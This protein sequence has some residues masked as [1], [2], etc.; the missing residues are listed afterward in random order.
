MTVFLLK[1][2]FM[3]KLI[4]LM[5]LGILFACWSGPSSSSNVD[6]LDVAIRD[7]SD[8]LNSNI[9][10]GSKI[11]ILNIQ[12]TSPDLSD[13]V[14]DE[15]IA[16]AV[17]DRVFSVVDRQQLDTIR[18]EQDFQMSGEVDDDDALAIGRFFGA[19]T[20]VSGAVNRLGTGYRIRIRALEVQTAQVQGQYNRNIASSPMIGAL[21]ES[22]G[23]GSTATSGGRTQ[24][25]S[26]APTT[27][28]PQQQT[29]Q[30]NVQAVPVQASPSGSAQPAQ[31][32][33]P[34]TPTRQAYRVGD[35][36]PAG[37]LIF[38]DKG[39]NS[40]GWRY[41]EAA[42]VEAEIR[43]VMNVSNINVD[44]TQATIGSGRRNTQLF[45][46]KLRQTAGEWDTAAQQ[47]D[48]LVFGGFDDWFIPSRDE[49]DQMYGNL[50]RRNLG[51]FKNEWYFSS[52]QAF[53]SSVHGQNFAN[54]SM[55]IYRSKTVR[56]YV[57]PIRQVE[58]P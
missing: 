32:S 43:A 11:V 18:A 8:Y 57:R 41:L 37:G 45:V 5:F 22:S 24:T 51:D 35:T 19:Q 9:P 21:M 44:N 50:K 38:Y 54:G 29:A 3:K 48:D 23:S 27:A 55:N 6:E 15:L 42:P 58:G 36:G 26:S 10:R 28:A 52:T 20:I 56:D 14:I 2:F 34:A 17:N 13:Y 49:L 47:C 16:N 53:T 4:V 12:S 33:Q 46:E 39:N 31:P 25:A 40:G 30:G 1:E 7:A